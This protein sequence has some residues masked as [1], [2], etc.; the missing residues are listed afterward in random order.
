MK[1]DKS[2][3]ALPGKSIGDGASRTANKG[4][5]DSSPAPQQGSTSVSLGSTA[6]QLRSMESSM[7]GSAAVDSAKVAEIKQA[8]SE[9]RFKV[10][11]EVVADRLIQTVRDLIG[12]RA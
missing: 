1:I 5:A 6:T 8:I 2:S 3:N 9:G 7:A 12:S 4:K 10:N 11:S